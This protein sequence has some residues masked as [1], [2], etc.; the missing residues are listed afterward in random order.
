MK[1]KIVP[2]AAASLILMVVFI[3]VN[4]DHPV[5]DRILRWVM[6]YLDSWLDIDWEP[7][8]RWMSV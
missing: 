8:K 6:E 3:A 7:I 2:I 1:K 4:H 5:L